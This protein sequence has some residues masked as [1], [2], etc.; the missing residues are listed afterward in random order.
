MLA[1]TPIGA[2]G[3]TGSY[4]YLTLAERMRVAQLTVKHGGNVSVISGIRALCT[5]DVLALAG[6]AQEAMRLSER[7]KPLWALFFR[8]GGS[9]RVVATAA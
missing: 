6:K 2:L 5:R 4:A 8:H 3:S 9:V 7:L 1:S